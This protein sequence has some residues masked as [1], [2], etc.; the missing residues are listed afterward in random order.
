[1]QNDDNR[2]V[3]ILIDGHSLAYRSYFALER[4]GMRNSDNIPTWGVYGFFKAFFDL[5]SRVKPDAIAISFDVSKK[6]FRN[7]QFP[8]YKAHR[9]PMPDDMRTQ[10]GLIRQGIESLNIPIYE[11]EG[12]EAD[13][14]IGTLTSKLLNEGH[15]VVILTGDQDSFQLIDDER[16]TVLLPQKGELTPFNRGKVYEKL[17]VYPEQLADYKG[18][19][20][21]SSDN[22]PGVKG[23]GEKTAQELLN[24]FGTLEEVYANLEKVGKKAVRQKLEAERDKAFLSKDLAC[25]RRNVE[26]DFDFQCCTL[27]IPNLDL[28]VEFLKTMEFRAF[29]DNYPNYLKIS[30]IMTR[31][32]LML[33]VIR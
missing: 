5:I 29:Y 6:T 14:V 32:I 3:V 23:I 21:D 30:S 1:M 20:G 4:T 27:E 10:M 12:F 22:I 28:F 13:D 11:Q 26:L 24:Q 8:E 16:V 19:R 9:P 33:M 25:I 31:S 7:E 15:K 18:L 17:G 2:K